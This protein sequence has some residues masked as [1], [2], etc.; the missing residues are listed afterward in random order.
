MNCYH[1]HIRGRVQ[2]IGFRPF[3]YN[4]SVENGLKGTVS[5]TPDGVHIEINSSP[6]FF[7]SYLDLIRE[8]A[9]A[10][11]LITAITYAEIPYKAF[12]DF[13]ISESG[14]HG[15]PDLLIT[16]DF[17][18]CESCKIELNDSGNRRYLYPFITCTTCGPRFSI[19]E[20]LPYDRQRTSMKTFT[21]CPKCGLEY[22]APS[23]RRFYSQTNSCPG[24]K[25]S[26]WII[27]Q[28]GIQ[29][30]VDE[31]E[32]VDFICVKIQEGS[33]VAVKGIG[34]FLLICDASNKQKVQELRYKKQR[35]AKPFA[36]MYPNMDFVTK[37]HQLSMEEK[38]AMKSPAAPIV[39]L[40][41]KEEGDASDLLPDIAPKL[42]SLGVMLP[43]APILILIAEKWNRPLLATSGNQKGSPVIYRNEEAVKNLGKFADY[44]LLNNREIQIPQDD[45]VVK[46]TKKYHQ[47]ILIRRS[48]GYAPG[49]VDDSI[50]IGFHDHVLSMGALLKS[51]FCV[52]QNG[53]C[54]VS[55]FLGDTTEFD[56]QLSYDRTLN[57]FQQLL[58]FKPEVILVDKH[59][60]YFSTLRGKE[61]AYAHEIPCIEIQHHEAHLWAVL[62]ENQLLDNAEKILGVI[63]DGT[64]MGSDGAVWG[65]EFYSVQRGALER[66][67]HIKYYPHILGD[68]MVREPRLSALS[69]LY[70]FGQGMDL[71]HDLFT[72]EEFEYYHKVLERSSLKTSS[73]GRIFDAVSCLLGLC[74][75]NSYEGEAAMY[76]ECE[77]QKH[78]DR[79]GAYP[80]SYA[81]SVINND[82]I[83]F[84][85]IISAIVNDI[86][87]ERP[88]GEIAAK[89]HS[90]LVRIIEKITEMHHATSIACSGG[91]FQ[92]GLLVD[93]LIDT[94]GKENKLFFH[95]ELSPNDECISY[96]QLVSYYVS[97][98]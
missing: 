57:H 62:G 96:G 76:L 61:L 90:T 87:R 75:I 93:M 39:L 83:D 28:Q 4:L 72:A 6:A 69:L 45:S 46:F 94:L 53:R 48:R 59:P 14:Q 74:Q 97:Q 65:G 26:Q 64:G 35:K 67:N 84:K 37:K 38:E 25:I 19:E 80:E 18:T 36:L 44:I 55:Q 63:F 9:P 11:S 20:M 30:N 13:I 15:S 16:P 82:P 68:K 79:I 51:T 86:N 91:V 5:N 43:Y 21:M 41:V 3:I 89:F 27:D 88:I 8:N 56:A 81:F 31:E 71:V 95:K 77:A 22:E 24:C 49:M 58:Q 32:I 23:D 10:Q 17:A 92:N 12:P 52:W 98:R 70:A 33:I 1:I 66:V 54:H 78:C 47:K 7:E 73:I 40:N 34:G 2:G 42:H 60:A 29:L 50:S 85:E